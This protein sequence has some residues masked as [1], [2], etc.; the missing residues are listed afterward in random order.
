[1][2]VFIGHTIRL[3]L[4]A[5][6][7]VFMSGAVYAQETSSA[8]Q[9]KLTVY[10]K[11]VEPFI[12]IKD[13]KVEGGYSY[14]TWNEIS[15][16]LGIEYQWKVVDTTSDLLANV[17]KGKD[18]A[19]IAAISI[20]SQREK[21][22]DFTHSYYESG[23]QI[24][25][26]GEKNSSPLAL[27]SSLL[28]ADLLRL[29]LLIIAITFVFS[30]I[31]WLF[32]RKKNPA[33]FPH[34]YWAGLGE[35]VWF[36][37]NTIFNGSCEEKS[38]ITFFGRFLTMFTVLINI[39]LVSAFTATL[40]ATMTMDKLQG[41]IKGPEGLPGKMVA[42]VEKTTS[43]SWVRDAGRAT[44]FPQKNVADAVKML[45]S[46]KVQAVVYDAP[47][48]RY[49]LKNFKNEKLMMVGPV[50]EDQGYGIALPSGDPLRKRLNETILEMQESGF[51]KELNSKYFGDT[52]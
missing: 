19:G 48:L 41:S 47:M 6:A 11:P 38:P 24:M 35:S 52:N 32:E 20:T 31:V 39:T 42:T 5:L 49:H 3:L 34:G 7:V 17:E 28:S 37:F 50:F 25:T 13:G 26:T 15:K 9:T 1:M 12:I 43:D 14:E 51:F 2:K 33:Q 40:S 45:E 21:V 22:I 36:S 30:N 27:L 46:G 8:Q 10:T 18:C 23:L 44:A 29:L 16:R 4:L